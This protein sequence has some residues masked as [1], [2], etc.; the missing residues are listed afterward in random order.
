MPEPVMASS[1]SLKSSPVACRHLLK[2]SLPM[3]AFAGVVV[4]ASRW[5]RSSCRSSTAPSLITLGAIDQIHQN[6]QPVKA[7]AQYGMGMD[8]NDMM[9]SDMLVVVDEFDRVITVPQPVSK[10][11]GHTFNE[12]SPRGVAHRA[13]S[14]CLFNEEGKM[15]LTQRAKT[16]ITFPGVWTNTCC[17]HP[18]YGKTPNEVDD[19]IADFPEFPGI[20]HAA[21]RKLKHELGIDPEEVPHDS[22]R[23]LSRFHYWAADTV[24]YGDTT[25]WGE[26]EVDYVLFVQCRG[27]GPA[28]TIDPEEVESYKYVTADELSIMFADD[29]LLWSPWFR[30]IMERRGFELWKNLGEAMRR[31]S[32]CKYV[33][34]SVHYFECDAH[35]ASYNLPSHS[36]DTGVMKL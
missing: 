4:Q 18:L 11:V 2:T 13:F 24:T 34:R 25:P 29:S 9:E 26:H 1:V 17:S 5:S 14:V 16:K 7:E 27:H 20:K 33:D 21:I 6:Q 31:S 23:F 32:E 3:I 30:G 36:R 22:F 15:L 10:K 8:Q 28:L 19:G 12:Q 35:V